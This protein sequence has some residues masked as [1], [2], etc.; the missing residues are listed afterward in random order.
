MACLSRPN[1]FNFLKVVIHKFCLV[2]SWTVSFYD[3]RFATEIMCIDRTFS[4]ILKTG[5]LESVMFSGNSLEQF[6]DNVKLP[7]QFGNSPL[8]LL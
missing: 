4:F 6:C 8:I 5:S 2:H 3:H 1:Y 7:F